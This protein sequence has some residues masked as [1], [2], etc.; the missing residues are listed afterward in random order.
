MAQENGG[1]A[2]DTP[3]GVTKG[4]PAE[5]IHIFV[6]RRKF[7]VADGVAERMT[8]SQ[9]AALVGVPGANAVVRREIG[10]AQGEVGADQEIELRQA[11]HFLVTRRTVE[12]GFDPVMS[13]PR[14]STDVRGR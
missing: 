9:I 13:A 2:P 4:P 7:G 5:A 1:G 14:G 6:N 10:P 12:G 11:E 3:G 8:G